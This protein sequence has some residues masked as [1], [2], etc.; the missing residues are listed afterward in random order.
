MKLKGFWIFVFVL[1]IFV[2]CQRE[3]NDLSKKIVGDWQLVNFSTNQKIDNPEE[4]R[5][6]AKQLIM[7]T[8][9]IIRDDGTIKSIIWG[10]SDNGYWEIKKDELVVYDKKKKTRFKARI[11]KLT[12]TQLLLYQKMGKVKV[13]L[14]FQRFD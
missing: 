13:V 4:Y 2:S 8:A 7:T 1:G 9:L 12:D 11:V 3:E 5:K 10:T 14:Y 6:A